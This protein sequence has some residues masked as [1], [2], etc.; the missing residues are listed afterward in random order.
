MLTR[1]RFNYPQ[2][3][4]NEQAETRLQ[5]CI[6]FVNQKRPDLEE[7]LVGQF[8]RLCCDKESK[9]NL[10]PDFAPL[11]FYFVEQYFNKDK[12]E[13]QRWINGGVIF[14]GQHDGGGNGGAPTFSV[15]ISPIDGWSIH[16]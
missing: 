9:V 1:E 13:W 12:Q 5:E 16:T 7:Q 14:H 8:D 4:V 11:S 6:D 2:L 10:Y 15:N 3:T